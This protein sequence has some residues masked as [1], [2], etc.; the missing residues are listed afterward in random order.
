MKVVYNFIYAD[1][2]GKSREF[3]MPVNVT[4]DTDADLMYDLCVSYLNICHIGGRFTL[5]QL[6]QS[7]RTIA[8]RPQ[9]VMMNVRHAVR[10]NCQAQSRINPSLLTGRRF[11]FMK[12]SSER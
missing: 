3:K 1:P 5:F 7:I 12:A 6:L 4:E 8:L 11:T 10:R 9:P 2:D